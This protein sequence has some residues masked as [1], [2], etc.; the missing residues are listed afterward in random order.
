MSAQK[1]LTGGSS[2][3]TADTF[4]ANTLLS[5]S[6]ATALSGLY[7]LS[8]TIALPTFATSITTNYTTGSNLNYI[9][10]VTAPITTLTLTGIPT[11]AQKSYTFVYI[12][13]ATTGA[14]YITGGTAFQING[15]ATTFS[16][17][18][19]GLTPT[20]Y[21]V[22]TINVVNISTTTTPSWKVFSTA[23]SI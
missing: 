3:N 7:N 21:I 10:S 23:T 19:S 8:E 22:Q 4:T 12:L 18:I 9:A 11:T 14:N 17:A 20:A 6:T 5:S 1:L 13:A 16:N 2:A 15:S